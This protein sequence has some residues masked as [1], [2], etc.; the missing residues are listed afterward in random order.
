MAI[1]SGLG[2]SLGIATESVVGTIVSPT[3]WLEFNSESLSLE[4][5]VLQGAGIRGGGL[6]PR[7]TR[8]AVTGRNAGGD[9]ELDLATSG[10]GMLFRQMLGSSTSAVLSGSAYQQVHTPGDLT[11]K[12]LTVQKL[13][14]D[15]AGTLVPFT[16]NGCKVA[17]W[18]IAC[19]V[20]A[21][22]TLRLT[23]DAKD[24]TTATAAGTPA[25]SATA[26]VFH[27]GQ[28]S[29]VL[30]GT[31]ATSSGVTSVTGGSTVASV[32]GVT[33][34]YNL[35]L[36]TG[37]DNQR[38]GMK[39][40]QSE[41]AWRELTGNLDADFVSQAAI[42]DTFSADTG[43]ALKVSFVGSTAISGAAYPTLEIIVPEIR[44][45][46]STPQ[47][48]GPD[49]ISIGAGFTGLQNAALDPVVQIRYVT[50]DTSIG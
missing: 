46:G 18:S 5:T 30:G 23:L 4:K 44:F 32:R 21:I 25:Y 7:A 2:A 24:E 26:Q 41:A 34:D 12:S 38:I 48:G 17:S 43:V 50:P 22:A 14:P 33:L 28:A 8:R 37:E 39:R 15:N 3:R 29:L 9:V 10:M 47:V 36:T 45:D 13:V 16:Y 42:Y 49:L 1:A 20:G 31:V 19:E 27:F 35:N 11:G 6:H 40:E